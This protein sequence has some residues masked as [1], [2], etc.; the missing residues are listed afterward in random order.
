MSLPVHIRPE[1]E[2]DLEDAA[3]WYE[4]QREG[5]GQDF[6]DESQRTFDHISENPRLYPMLHRETRRA[7]VRRFPFGVFYKVEE[8]SI[9]V[10]AV[11]HASRHPKQWKQTT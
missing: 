3:A 10:V 7:V 9:V 1:A 8:A 5:L 11:M 2:A 4:R 6:L